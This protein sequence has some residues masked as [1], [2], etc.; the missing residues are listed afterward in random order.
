[1]DDQINTK[2]KTLGQGL[3]SVFAAQDIIESI[4]KDSNY[5]DHKEKILNY[6]INNILV[7]KIIA[8]K[9]QPR[10]DFNRDEL[11][12]LANSIREH[13]ILQPILVREVYDN[14]HNIKYEIIAG[15]R[16]YRAACIVNLQEIP[17]IILN[18]EDSDCIAIAL[19]ENIQRNNLNPIEEATSYLKLH[20]DFG[21]THEQISQMVGRSRSSIT[22]SLRLIFLSDYVK[23]LIKDKVLNTGQAKA[24][25]GL[26]QEGQK[27]IADKIVNMSCNTRVAEK[28]VSDYKLSL[29]HQEE[30][31]DK[32]IVDANQ[33]EQIE[34]WTERLSKAFNQAVNIK[35]NSKTNKYNLT[36]NVDTL[37]VLRSIVS[38]VSDQNF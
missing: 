37:D 31:I 21:Y 28:L 1:M 19:V 29:E 32:D 11:Y 14:Y 34:Y 18:I 27:I 15:E 20:K 26:D 22:N 2:N 7:R 13:G 16:R 38:M 5:S 36:I 35:Y 33:A 25:A 3:D 10:E 8:G 4:N 23:N 17:A 24:L 30:L 6:N 9:Y 12:K